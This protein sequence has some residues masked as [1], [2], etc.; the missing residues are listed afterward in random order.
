MRRYSA[1][2]WH[3]PLK[4]FPKKI[5]IILIIFVF[6]HIYIDIN[7]RPYLREYAIE[8]VEDFAYSTI[9][10][11]IMQDMMANPDNYTSIATIITNNQE[12][13]VAL[14][15]DTFKIN[16]IKS[17]IMNLS[18]TQLNLGNITKINV[19]IGNLY[20]NPFLFLSGIE[21]PVRV[22]NMST[23]IIDIASSFESKGI[24][25]SLHRIILECSVELK[26]IT[27]YEEIDFKIYHEVALSETLVLGNVPNSYTYIGNVDDE[28]YKNFNYILE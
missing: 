13:L 22:I 3:R 4:K 24:N 27:P 18:D 7:L 20:K 12:Q 25:Q 1:R 26:I 11:A 8:E 2:Y 9:N 6:I 5:L 19:P 16:Q 28:F 15:T 23:T 14:E 10:E 17:N 21:L